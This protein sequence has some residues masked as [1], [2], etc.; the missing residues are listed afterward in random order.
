[1]NSGVFLF[2]IRVAQSQI[3]AFSLTHRIGAI[4]HFLAR[5]V[6]FT[7]SSTQT[8]SARAARYYRLARMACKDG[9][10]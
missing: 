2:V 1:M 8:A 10:K 6:S 3:F 7:S 4:D 5:K 9:W